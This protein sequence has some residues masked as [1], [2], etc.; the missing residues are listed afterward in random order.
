M[1]VG[2]IITYPRANEY[3][4]KVHSFSCFQKIQIM[5]FSWK[6]YTDVVLGF[7]RPHLRALSV[8]MRRWDH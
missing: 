4:L 8:N 2:F 3:A 5:A 7:L 1:K 6:A